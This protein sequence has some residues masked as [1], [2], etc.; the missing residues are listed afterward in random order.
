MKGLGASSIRWG[1]AVGS[2]VCLLL[3]SQTAVAGDG[4]E[5]RQFH[6]MPDQSVNF[7][8]TASAEVPEHRDWSASM[9]L[10]YGRN[11]LVWRDEQGERVESL[12]SHQGL[13]HLMVSGGALGVF[14]LGLDLPVVFSQSGAAVDG[15]ELRGDQSS[16]GLG[17]MRLV[18][19]FQLFSTREDEGASGVATALI[20][21]LHLP[22][23]NAEQLQGGD[24][25][26]GPRFA[27]DAVVGD[28][29]TGLNLGYRYRSQ[30]EVGNLDVR[31]TFGWNL[32][33]EVPVTDEWAA[34]GEVFGRLTTAADETRRREAPTEL[35]VGGKYRHDDDLLFSLGGGPGLVNGYGT[36]DW[37]MFASV[38]WTSS[39]PPP[40]PPPECRPETAE[41][42]CGPVPEPE[43]ADGVL[44]THSVGCADGEC[45]MSSSSRPCA[46]DEHC[47][48]V[49]GQPACVPELECFEDGD[50]EDAPATTCED[51]VVT[52]WVGRCIDGE[53]DYQPM[54]T[55]CEDD[56]EC[57]VVDGTD[58]CVPIPERVEVDEQEERIEIEEVIHF[59]VDSAEIQER[60][61]SLLDEV[62]HVLWDHP[63]IQRVRIE[64]HTDDTGPRD[65][66]IELSQDR[67]ESVRQYLVDA[68]IDEERL[69]AVGL[70]PDE[71]IADND[72]PE[73]REENRRVEF[74]IE[75]RD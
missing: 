24:F 14:E 64:G 13:A 31:D 59:E 63:E 44:T 49:D 46:E 25:R 54:E 75:Q 50:C 11:P 22:T 27:V 45:T 51:G 37:R 36:P 7:F 1:L 65:Y 12:V 41:A 40:D 72:T 56:E 39:D 68:G 73:G 43:C 35:L 48:T 74:H 57:G 60:S 34:T 52:S 10:D 42:D 16:F 8:G 38:S 21:D 30:T 32:G 67:A 33:V 62:A 55:V 69:E 28:V 6:P 61:F 15:V 58:S 18:P 17:D 4:F 29:H 71:P 53:C 47:G 9:M 3:V 19:K 23:G 5:P 26:A 20:M 66:N 2:L 70:G